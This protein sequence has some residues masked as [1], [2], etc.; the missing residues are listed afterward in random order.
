MKTQDLSRCEAI[1]EEGVVAMENSME[2]EGVWS[3]TKTG[4]GT[5]VALVL[6]KAGALNSN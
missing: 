2:E 3:C 1:R 5:S 6:Q 4:G